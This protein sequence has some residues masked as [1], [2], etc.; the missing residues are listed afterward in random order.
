MYRDQV[1]DGHEDEVSTEEES[2]IDFDT[3]ILDA[4]P[5]PVQD[6][7]SVPDEPRWR[8]ANADL[9]NTLD[10]FI[11]R[12]NARDLDDLSELLAPDAE[13]DFLGEMSSEGI[14]DGLEDLTLRYPTL[15]V[16]RGDLGREPIMVAWLFD[17][18]EDRYDL[19]GYF[20]VEPA[21]ANDGL[22]QRLAYIEELPETDELVVE[23]PDKVEL[24][25]WEDWSS[26]EEG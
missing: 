6:D 23:T 24:Q 17:Q 14:I 22:I 25:E 5:Q 15:V 12:V 20:T 1:E 16:T 26:F 19:V 3:D 18:G 21:P 2:Q 8:I 9:D 10:E 11:E 4:A 13:A 7:G